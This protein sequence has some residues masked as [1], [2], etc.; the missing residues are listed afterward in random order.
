MRNSSP[1]R[2]GI[3]P[4]ATV[5]ISVNF[6]VLPMNYLTA[7]AVMD[8]SIGQDW[9]IW[10]SFRAFYHFSLYSVILVVYQVYLAVDDL[11]YSK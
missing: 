9:V 1:L 4:L 10:Y 11:C 6:L 3:V 8:N 7:W 2:N 5:Q